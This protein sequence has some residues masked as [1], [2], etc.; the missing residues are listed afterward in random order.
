MLDTG[1]ALALVAGLAM[2]H[3]RRTTPDPCREAVQPRLEAASWRA[4]AIASTRRIRRA[5]GS[6]TAPPSRVQPQA[7]AF[8]CWHDMT[9]IGSALDGSQAA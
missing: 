1:T 9:A 3:G 5:A 2:W 4:G 6:V 7:N 8:K